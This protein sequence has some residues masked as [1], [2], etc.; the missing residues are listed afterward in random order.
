MSAPYIT[1]H[2]GRYFIVWAA[3]HD[4]PAER[5]RNTGK[6]VTYFNAERACVAVYG[7]IPQPYGVGF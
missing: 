4:S 6:H 3:S 7:V 5:D 2:R 1:Q